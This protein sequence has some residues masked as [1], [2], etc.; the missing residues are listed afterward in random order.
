MWQGGFQ[1]GRYLLHF[2]ESRWR[3]RRVDVGLT[4]R[5]N[6]LARERGKVAFNLEAIC[7][8][9]VSQGNKM[10]RVYVGLA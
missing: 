1:S 5:E 3:M 9:S 8:T 10:S 6:Y 7:D 2:R 4:P